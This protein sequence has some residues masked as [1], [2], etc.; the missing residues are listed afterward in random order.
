MRQSRVE[1]LRSRLA[2]AGFVGLSLTLG[3][4]APVVA[5]DY[6]TPAS[7]APEGT[8]TAAEAAP[9]PV[10]MAAL[11]S[12]QM[13]TERPYLVAAEG[14]QAEIT[15]LLTSGEA[16]GD[17]VMAG[18]PDGL[19][20]T[21]LGD[22][23]VLFMNHEL[24]TDEDENISDARISRLVLDPMSAAV[25]SGTY[26]LDGTEG[27]WRLCS[28]SLAGPEVGFDPPVF[29]SGEESTGGPHGGMAIAVNAD[30]GTVTELPWLGHIAHEN[31][32]VIPGFEGKTVVV[33]TDD[34]SSGS[35]LY[36]YVADSPAG[37]LDGSGQ[38]YVFKADNAA[39][40]AD[41]KKGTELT[42]TFIPIDQ[43]DNTDAD[44][45][46]QKV[47]DEGA[48]KF[49][50]LEDVTYDR[51]TTTKL[52][53]TD[54]GDNED[55]NLATD[56]TPLTANGRLY[57]LTLDPA[58][59][60]KVTGFTVLLDGD[61]G[62]ALRNPDNIDADATT[63]MIQEDLNG[64]NRQENSDETGRIWAYD[65]ASGA[66]TEVARLDQS[67][68]EGLVDEGDEAGSW[69][70]SGILNVG[71]IFGEGAWLTDVQAHTLSVAQFGEADQGGQLLLIR[72]K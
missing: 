68:G 11:E 35:E 8:P 25:V 10:E 60:T 5:Q 54:T 61:A 72:I 33:T 46:Q 51:T 50:R 20:A 55:P 56:G 38:L 45:L 15:P 27:Y 66:L 53:F 62:D 63:V 16:V 67:A 39:G 32:V 52:Y 31:E 7:G 48:F 42:G 47:W 12:G 49:V 44:T 36:M 58:D 69:E 13:T 23:V 9:A 43:T 24:T 28:A 22:E 70:S 19:G 40:T 41:V 1:R 29:L 57:T 64:Y 14:A 4:F 30:D 21:K 34:D 2:V 17:Y 65:I 71:D 37:V 18:V 6:A 59:P 26:V 3:G